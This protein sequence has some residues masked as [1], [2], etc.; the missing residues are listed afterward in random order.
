MNNSK[1]SE[2]T[3]LQFTLILI[4]SM[5][6]ISVLSLPNYVI[7]IA[8]QDGW[9]SV[10]L[11]AIYPLYII[12]IA[13]YLCKNH[14]NENILVLS[15]KIFGNILGSILNLIFISYFI[16]IATK[17][18]TDVSSILH[19]YMVQFLNKWTLLILLYIL[20]AYT[21]WQGFKILGKLN[22]V[23]FFLTIIIFFIPLIALKDANIM[24]IKPILGTNPLN[25]ILAA[26]E[27]I[28]SY[29]LIEVILLLYPFAKDKGKIKSCG[30]K[31]LLFVTT[32]YVVFTITDILYFGIEASL[33]FLWPIVTVTESLVIPVINSF[34]FIFMS[35]WS[36]TMFKCIYNCY[37]VAIQ[38]LSQFTKKISKKAILLLTV[39]LMILISSF[40]GTVTKSNEIS[41]KIMPI[42]I[43]YNIIFTASIALFVRINQKKE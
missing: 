26:K 37:F 31:A 2:L 30:L 29:S 6:G 11:G 33:Q 27:T 42:F 14:P 24:N 20:I 35:L 38:E 15:K 10:I 7:Q 25:I 39:P 9:I 16:F 4:G 36:L 17:V 28:F 43:I 3:Q 12:F 21:I 5:L 34:R 22:E 1:T 8:K 40:Y 19:I 13:N 32:I 41:S 18:A 23:I